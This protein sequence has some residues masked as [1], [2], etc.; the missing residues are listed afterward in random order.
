MK[1]EVE[2]PPDYL[3]REREAASY[4][5]SKVGDIPGYDLDIPGQEKGSVIGR[6]C[7]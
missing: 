2:Q 1:G 3:E 4:L 7:I 6:Q 5:F